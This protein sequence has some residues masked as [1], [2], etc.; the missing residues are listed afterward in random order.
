MT[1]KEEVILLVTL[2]KSEWGTMYAQSLANFYYESFGK[3]VKVCEITSVLEELYWE[4]TIEEMEE[5]E[6]N[7]EIPSYVYN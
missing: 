4:T 2:W 6:A 3:Q 5:A 7:R 1:L